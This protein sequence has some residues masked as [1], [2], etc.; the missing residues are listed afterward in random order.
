MKGSVTLGDAAEEDGGAFQGHE[1]RKM[2]RPLNYG[3][4]PWWALL[5]LTGPAFGPE[6]GVDAHRTGS[7]IFLCV[8]C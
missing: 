5:F 7:G 6:T 4:Q 2:S 1:S 8:R 3:V